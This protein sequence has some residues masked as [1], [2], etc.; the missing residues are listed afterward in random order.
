MF[1]P[2]FYLLFF[3]LFTTPSARAASARQIFDHSEWDQFLKEF[4]NEKGDV[5]YRAAKQKPEHLLNYL[6]KVKSIPEE[7]LKE[8]PREEEISIFINTYNAAVA[9]LILDH[10]PVKSIMEIPGVWDNAVVLIATPSQTQKPEAYSLNQIRRYLLMQKFRDEKILFSLCAG[11]KGSPPLQR[12]AYTAP[13]LE[14][15][16]YL[17]TRKFANDPARNQI[18]PGEKKI[19][20]SRIFKWYGPDF[21][22]NWGDFP[23]QPRWNVEEKAVLSF[24]AHYLDDAKKV[25]FLKEGTYKIKYESFDWGLNDISAAKGQRA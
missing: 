4:V 7:H 16:L 14:G 20:L 1:F 10:Y 15:Q 25:E 17:V 23:D 8:W 5:D 19:V 22:L 6:E 24:F 13:R 11:A 12:E 9:K 2:L 3:F 21:L 18:V